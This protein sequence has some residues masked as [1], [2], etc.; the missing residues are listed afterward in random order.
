MTNLTELETQ[1]LNGLTEDAEEYLDGTIEY[2]PCNESSLHNYIDASRQSVGGVVASLLNKGLIHIEFI[3]EIQCGR[4]FKEEK[5]YGISDKGLKAIEESKDEEV[6]ALTADKIEILTSNEKKVLNAIVN[7]TY[8]DVNG[9]YIYENDVA[10]D[11]GLQFA[12]VKLTLDALLKKGLM[13]QDKD[14]F[15]N[16]RGK[17]KELNIYF[18]TQAGIDALKQE[19]IT[20]HEDIDFKSEFSCNDPSFDFNEYLVQTAENYDRPLTKKALENIFAEIE[21]H[22]KSEFGDYD[23]IEYALCTES[24]AYDRGLHLGSGFIEFYVLDF[25]DTDVV[26]H[27]V[28]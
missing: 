28:K 27:L 25:A 24:N 21:N 20:D 3:D 4:G 14:V 8:E 2:R 6:P 18:L 5:F 9:N 17:V 16:S 23:R 7:S 13:S 26:L 22:H 11:A 19:T 10:L 12:E 15:I 1:L